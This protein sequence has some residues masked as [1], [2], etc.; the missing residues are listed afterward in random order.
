[1]S[2]LNLHEPMVKRVNIR[3]NIPETNKSL[4]LK[5]DLLRWGL[6]IDKITPVSACGCE[7]CAYEVSGCFKAS[8]DEFFAICK[9]IATEYEIEQLCI[10]NEVN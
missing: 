7:V 1:M 6:C 3:F 4:K 5:D 9:S 2:A 8:W 10:E